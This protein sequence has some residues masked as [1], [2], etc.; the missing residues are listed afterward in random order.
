MVHTLERLD[1][2]LSGIPMTIVSGVFVVLSFILSLVSMESVFGPSLA[3]MLSTVDVAWVAVIVSG[4]PILYSAVRKLI[5]APGVKKL[6][7]ALLITVAMAAAIGIGDVF[8]AAEVAFI[9][10]IGEILEGYTTKRAEKGLEKLIHVLP[11]MGRVV[12]GDGSESF[13]KVEDI[14][15]GQTLRV[16]PGETVPVDGRI[17]LGDTS[18]DQSIMTGESVPVDKTS[19]D[20]VFAGTINHFGAFTM[21]ATKVGEDGSLQKL[22]RLVEDAK[23]HE[24]PMVRTIDRVASW[25]TPLSLLI[26]LVTYAITGDITRAVTVLIVF[27]PCALVLASPTAIMAAIGQATKQG[28]IIKSGEALEAMSAVSMVAFDKT[29]TLTKGELRISH[30]HAVGTMSD[31]EVLRLAASVEASSEHPLGKAIVSGAK[32]EGVTFSSASD[33]A[34]TLGRGVSALVGSERIFCGNET[35]LEEY[36][37]TPTESI[38]E[39]LLKDREKGLVPIIVAKGREIVGILSLGDVLRNESLAVVEDLTTLGVSSSLLTGDTQA[40]AHYMAKKVGITHV[41]AHL[42]PQEKVAAIR[43]MQQTYPFHS[44]AMVGDGIN[45]APA[46]KLANVGIVMGH[47]GSDLTMDA[48]DVVLMGDDM[49]KLSYV[50]RLAKATKRTIWMSL[51]LAMVINLV[52]VILS[53]MGMMSPTL[54]AIVHN[55]GSCVVIFLASLLYEKNIS[56]AKC[57][58]YERKLAP[59]MV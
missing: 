55:V 3:S 9:M 21:E 16:L 27:C 59:K 15:Q 4:F 23:D 26:A 57:T 40:T 52:A 53:V 30:I 24:A 1:G 35:Y 43:E 7:S 12:N 28:V 8:A 41:L 34:M 10:A 54:G 38:E 45:D 46:L 58:A 49:T 51:T 42:M 2:F 36:N 13:I 22:I 48:A 20:D 17:L 11:T 33:F 25:L 44:V 19:G 56:G 5:V 39:L 50:K 37:I 47:A 6:S 32:E 18:I 31:M 29:G 14:T